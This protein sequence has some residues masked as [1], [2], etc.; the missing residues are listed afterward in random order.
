MNVIWG[1]ITALSIPLAI[2]NMVGGIVSGVWLAILGEWGTIGCGIAAFLVSTLALSLVLM[3]AL[4]LAAPA[5]VC[6]ERG[7]TFGLMFFGALSSLYTIGVITAW[8]CGVLF[9]FSKNLTQASLIP[10]LVWSYGVAIGPWAYMSSKEQ[11]GGA[12]SF[13][14]TMATFLAELAYVV[15]I[16]LA[17]FTPITGI[18]AIKIF[19]GF[20]LVGL[21]IQMTFFFLIQREVRE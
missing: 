16:L 1:L 7:N 13:A 6:A 19:V 5:G 12:G 8:C 4:L 10:T 20:M 17:L 14:S 9:F 2:L 15:I 18:Q 3:P 11:H 21:V